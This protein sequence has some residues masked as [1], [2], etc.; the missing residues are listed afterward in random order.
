MWCEWYQ[1]IQVNLNKRPSNR[2]LLFALFLS[3]IPAF[4]DNWQACLIQTAVHTITSIMNPLMVDC[5][6]HSEEQDWTITY[7]IQSKVLN[8]LLVLVE[9]I[10]T[11]RFWQ[12]YNNRSVKKQKIL[13]SI[14]KDLFWICHWMKNDKEMI[15]WTLV[16]RL[17]SKACR[18][19]LMANLR[20][21]V[22]LYKQQNFDSHLTHT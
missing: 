4:A 7:D 8:M 3:S 1:L 17:G 12:I 16:P 14:L 9:P 15:Q 13:A 5:A 2:L 21:Q 20:S 10:I 22:L 6:Q 11:F 18:C 19:C